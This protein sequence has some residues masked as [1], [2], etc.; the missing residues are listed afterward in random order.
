M[1]N[2]YCAH[3]SARNWQLPFLNQKKGEND[4]TKY[5]LINLYERMLPISAGVKP[6]TSWS[7]VGCASNWV[8][9]ASSQ[10]LPF[11]HFDQ[12]MKAIKTYVTICNTINNFYKQ[13]AHEAW[14]G[15]EWNSHCRYAHVV[16]YFFNPI[17]ASYKRIII[18]AVL[19]FEE[20]ECVFY[21]YFSL[22]M[23]MGMTVSGA[24]PFEQTLNPI[25]TVGA[26]WPSGFQR[27]F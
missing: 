13:E 15:H 7:P 17:N 16:Q 23:Y 8:T 6:A 1:V 2:Q 19:G 22:Q 12:D 26:K 27:I 9:K 25:S 24:W 21:Y 14:L 18:W 11:V 4:R 10:K 3:S 20:E 5:F